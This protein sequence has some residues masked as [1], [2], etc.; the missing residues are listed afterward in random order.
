[1]TE[2]TKTL[3]KHGLIVLLGIVLALECGVLIGYRQGQLDYS[4]GFKT[5]MIV[6]GVEIHILGPFK[7]FNPPQ[8][9]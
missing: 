6:D 1:M 7:K 2:R 3:L 8:E 5:W 4:Q 9:K